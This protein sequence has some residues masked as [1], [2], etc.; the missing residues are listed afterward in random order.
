MIRR[1]DAEM[2][3]HKYRNIHI[4]NEPIP[5]GTRNTS[6]AVNTVDKIESSRNFRMIAVYCREIYQV[7]PYLLC[8]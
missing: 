8:G 1:F 4:G 2:P 5:F 7:T 3:D 6:D